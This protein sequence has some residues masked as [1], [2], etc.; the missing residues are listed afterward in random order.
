MS[1][2]LDVE[3]DNPPPTNPFASAPVVAAPSERALVA[4]EVGEVHAAVVLAKN[5]PRDQKAAVDRIVTACGRTKLAAQATYEYARGG[6]EITGPSIR[7]AEVIAREWGNI[8]T[9][10]VELSRTG[11]VSEAMAYA[12]DLETNFFDEKRFQVK[13]W[14]DTKKGGYAVTDERDVYEILAN[15]GARRKRAC[16]L[17]AVPGDVV[18]TALEACEAT[19]K[20]NV[21]AT[22]EN[23]QK[24]M[25]AFAKYGVT[26]A[27]V[28]KRIQRRLDTI[29]PGLLL[30]LLRIGNSLRDGMSQ[31]AD[32]FD[33]EPGD[34][35]DGGISPPSSRT[36]AV[37]DALKKSAGAPEPHPGASGTEPVPHDATTPAAE[38]PGGVVGA[39]AEAGE[40]ST[41]SEIDEKRKRAREEADAK[42]ALA[43]RII[44]AAKAA[45]LF[46]KGRKVIIGE[47]VAQSLGI[48]KGEHGAAELVELGMGDE[49]AIW[50][51]SQAPS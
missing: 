45:A 7:L 40:V 21:P 37:K 27:M 8:R 43:D 47:A 50:L 39:T 48:E 6:Q 49:V 26:P 14:R 22:P 44:K 5:F 33:F 29:T 28:E 32:W 16:I 31:A 19:L 23:V 17:A 38:V 25:G 9:G 1:E 41:S 12:W 13:H 51:E 3:R 20:A 46:S 18:E 24:I 2:V 34:G 36:D 10:V 42:A 11:G 30:Q 35:G 15:Q 4:R